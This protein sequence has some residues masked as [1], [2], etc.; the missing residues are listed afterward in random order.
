MMHKRRGGGRS[1][2]LLQ[3]LNC[4]SP[5]E[6]SRI[7]SSTYIHA[8]FTCK[9]PKNTWKQHPRERWSFHHAELISGT[10]KSSDIIQV[11][12]LWS[13]VHTFMENTVSTLKS[14]VQVWH[15]CDITDP[16]T[17]PSIAEI[18]TAQRSWIYSYCRYKSLKD[19]A[20]RHDQPDP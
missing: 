6:H 12:P 16:R 17:L 1:Y 20:S 19:P 15:H 4:V 18:Y 11:F 10:R 8:H 5:T 9:Q 14:R 7:V 13:G 2:S 3:L